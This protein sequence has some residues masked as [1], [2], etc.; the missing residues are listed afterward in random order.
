MNTYN[1]N[2]LL[3]RGMEKLG[4]S[5]NIHTLHVLRLLP[6]LQFHVIDDP[7]RAYTYSSS[8]S[9][10]TAPAA[11]ICWF[12]KR[13]PL[14]IHINQ[15]YYV[16]RSEVI[17]VSR[18]NVVLDDTLVADCEKVTGLKT[19]RALID[20]ALQELLRHERQKKVLELKGTVRWE[21]NLATWRKRRG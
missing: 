14:D 21:G 4:P 13:D 19:R 11:R 1:P 12:S 18:T 2:D 20:H 9:Q 5:G 6:K 17:Q 16:Y 10:K 8:G 3:L 15:S 7:C